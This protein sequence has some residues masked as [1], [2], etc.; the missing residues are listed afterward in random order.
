MCTRSLLQGF[1]LKSLKDCEVFFADSGV[2]QSLAGIDVQG[3]CDDCPKRWNSPEGLGV[4][5]C[6]KNT[7]LDY[8]R[9]AALQMVTRIAEYHGKLLALALAELPK[10]M[11]AWHK[12]NPT[13]S[14][15]R[16]RNI[17]Q[18]NTDTANTLTHKKSPLRPQI[19]NECEDLIITFVNKGRKTG[20]PSPGVLLSSVLKEYKREA[21]EFKTKSDC[22][23]FFNNPQVQ[24]ALGVKMQY[25][26]ACDR[27]P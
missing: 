12:A 21:Q 6:V 11:Y 24:Q 26:G 4:E 8:H 14:Q 20:E 3:L 25:K 1:Q 7:F 13:K 17:L 9:D 16:H 10:T 5:A 22:E 2:Q 23:K 18:A 19:R 15:T 27:C